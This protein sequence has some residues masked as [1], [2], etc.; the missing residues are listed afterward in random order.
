VFRWLY[1]DATVDGIDIPAGSTVM[2]SL[3]SSNRDQDV[4]GDP[5]QMDLSRKG[6][7]NHFS[8][9][10]GV[11]YCLGAML[12]RLELQIALERLLDRTRNI[13]IAPGASLRRENMITVRMLKSLPVVFTAAPKS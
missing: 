13:R 9:G 1:E 6:I 8:F 4:V 5:T 2:V 10:L 7:R 12:A 11:H 3:A